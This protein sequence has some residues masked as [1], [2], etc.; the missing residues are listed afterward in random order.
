MLKRERARSAVRR[1]WGGYGEVRVKHHSKYFGLSAHG[2]LGV[3][4]LNIRVQEGLVGVG[5]EQ[6]GV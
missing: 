6:C 3:S 5:C 4:K 2:S 1:T